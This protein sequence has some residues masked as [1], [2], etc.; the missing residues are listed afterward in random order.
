MIMMNLSQTTLQTTFISKIDKICENFTGILV[1]VPEVMDTP[2]LKT[3]AS[4]TLIQVTK[5][6]AD[7]QTKSCKLDPIPTYTCIKTNASS[8]HLY[9]NAHHQYST[10]QCLLLQRVEDLNSKTTSKKKGLDLLDKN[11]RPVSNLPFLSK[12]VK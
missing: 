12:L 10:Q 4:L 11:F 3:F 8:P 1:F 2:T 7:M 5:H 9:N 6:I